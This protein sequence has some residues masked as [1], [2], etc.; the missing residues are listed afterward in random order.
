LASPIPTIINLAIDEWLPVTLYQGAY[1]QR[2]DLEQK[3]CPQMKKSYPK[4]QMLR[5]AWPWNWRILRAELMICPA[6]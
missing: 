6:I 3:S 2:A 1:T 4:L 5:A